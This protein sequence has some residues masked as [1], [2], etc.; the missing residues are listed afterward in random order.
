MRAGVHPL[1]LLLL[2]YAAAAEPAFGER[3]SADWQSIITGRVFFDADDNGR[4]GPGD[5]PLA[6]ARLW[7]DNSLELVCDGE[8]RFHLT[9]AQTGYDALGGH[10]L[11][12]D[13]ES[14]PAGMAAKDGSVRT[15]QLPP[16]G[17]ATV[18]FVLEAKAS[19]AQPPPLRLRPLAAGLLAPG[20]GGV[21][22]R[23]EIVENGGCE[24]EAFAD[25][26]ILSKE[27]KTILEVDLSGPRRTA[28][29][30][31][32]CAA[33]G[34]FI[35]ALS[36]H[37]VRGGGK[38]AT[39]IAEEPLPLAGCSGFDLVRR[40]RQALV[41]CRSLSAAGLEF[42]GRRVGNN[43]FL[44][45]FPAALA[46]ANFEVAVAGQTFSGAVNWEYSPRLFQ[47]LLAGRSV[48]TR[49]QDSSRQV[50]GSARGRLEFHLDG[51]SRLL[52]SLNLDNSLGPAKSAT[53]WFRPA[54]LGEVQLRYPSA[55]ESYFI[56]ADGA[57]VIDADPA[58]SRYLLEI[59]RRTSR[60]GYGHFRTSFREAGAGWLAS[61]HGFFASVDVLEQFSLSDHSLRLEGFFARPQDAVFPGG[62]NFT[63]AVPA[64]DEF[65]ASGGS[66]YLLSH[67]WLV[68]GSARVAV[69]VRDAVTGLVLSRRELQ[70]GADYD[71]DH[72]SGRLLLRRPLAGE[73][74]F[75]FLRLGASCGGW[76]VLVVDYYRLATGTEVEA[77]L[78]GG[79]LRAAS[80]LGKDVSAGT[81]LDLAQQG[82]SSPLYRRW[83]AGA[84]IKGGQFSFD[85]AYARSSGRW[86]E[87]GFST[88]GGLWFERGP[89]IERQG[90][91][92]WQAS[93]SGKF[94]TFRLQAGWRRLLAGYS[95]SGGQAAADANQGLFNLEVEPWSWLRT[96][97]R[98]SFNWLEHL[99]GDNPLAS[100]YQ[101]ALDAEFRPWGFLSVTTSSSVEAARGAYGQG[102]RVLLGGRID[103]RAADW[104]WFFG[105]YQHTLL[106]GASGLVEP[107]LTFGSLGGQIS[108]Q[109]WHLGLEGG[110]GPELGS[111][112]AADIQKEEQYVAAFSRTGFSP[113]ISGR[114]VLRMESGQT[115]GG[116]GG[117]KI[118]TSQ[119]IEQGPGRQA[120]GRR[121]EAGLPLASGW[122]LNFG[123]ERSELRGQS[124]GRW[125]LQPWYYLGL[126]ELSAPTERNIFFGRTVWAGSSFALEASGELRT[127][128]P[129]AA[130][131]IS[132]PDLRQT[133]L[134]LAGRWLLAE[135]LEA[136]GR[137]LWSESTSEKTTGGR[138]ELARSVE[139]ALGLGWRPQDVPWLWLL[140]RFSAGEEARPEDFTQPAFRSAGWLSATLAL[141]AR[142]WPFFQPLVALAPWAR[143]SQSPGPE[144]REFFWQ[145]G[146]LGMLRLGAEIYRGLGAA[147][148]GRAAYS[149]T[150][151]ELIPP[152]VTGEQTL[153]WAAEV[154]YRLEQE[155]LGQ[156][157]V[158]M[159]YNF[160]DMPDPLL[161]NPALGTGQRG[162]FIRL[163]GAL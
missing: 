107:S 59:E 150:P 2:S 122:H 160:S 65:L 8:G 16:L 35:W 149:R 145:H 49:L 132:S 143:R 144:G 42:H 22:A 73:A 108:H 163:E 14:L 97:G 135:N 41:E 5:L 137:L 117:V 138:R 4:F 63:R 87:N 140:A 125:L 162:L 127:Q 75:G 3:K 95:D 13:E 152:T 11:K 66:L 94:E 52:L 90:G 111:L 10:V 157:R 101:G 80:R 113:D 124:S 136:G 151:F 36:V 161:Q 9:G 126:T 110:W 96:S 38:P 154:F 30:V 83:S 93:F 44:L 84:F 47:G 112:L 118:T 114:P 123:F 25:G 121:L 79:A 31:Q 64:R 131:E 55:A 51:D 28:L 74:F 147:A 18:D 109:K 82:L 45:D 115:A 141:E 46:A 37:M 33:Q 15:V 148:E 67:N 105:R 24:V 133:V 71:I 116:P 120:N 21:S 68:E 158:S 92:V 50:F 58:R 78:F 53:D 32:N 99:P 81:R 146:L 54:Y 139:A 7:L 76:T 88:D 61:L 19:V 159:G 27:G 6:G 1:A 26:H 130:D 20:A 153:G 85:A 39:V 69:E 60:A 89:E 29:L 86:N 77:E 128:Q 106:R 72:H 129:F 102:Q 48:F 70:A 57:E 104:L 43:S 62:E 103:W 17:A 34:F 23:L 40:R 91:E 100:F 142:P 134:G 98:L 119:T 56:F 12:L 155:N 156:L